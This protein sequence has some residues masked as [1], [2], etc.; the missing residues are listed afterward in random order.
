MCD[1]VEAFY[2]DYAE[3]DAEK[4]FLDDDVDG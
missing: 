3:S 1:V 4:E 2:R